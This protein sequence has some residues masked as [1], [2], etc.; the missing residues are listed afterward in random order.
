MSDPLP[1]EER[2][3]KFRDI[4]DYLSSE[5]VR[6]KDPGHFNHVFTSKLSGP[7]SY[8]MARSVERQEQ[9]LKESQEQ[10]ERQQQVL[11]QMKEQSERIEKANQKT[12]RR[13]VFIAVCS[14]VFAIVAVIG[15]SISIRSSSQWR[16]EQI[17]LLRKIVENQSNARPHVGLWPEQ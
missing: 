4:F 1:I 3:K 6:G 7:A 13:T 12:V 10:A 8:L 15:T 2:D 14:L 17:P 5:A 9:V 16:R 11:E